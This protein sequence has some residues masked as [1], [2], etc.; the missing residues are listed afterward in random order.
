MKHHEFTFRSIG[1]LEK[2]EN[3]AQAL[4]DIDNVSKLCPQANQEIEKIE[5]IPKNSI[6]IQTNKTHLANGIAIIRT[7]E[8]DF[9]EGLPKKFII[10]NALM[11]ESFRSGNTRQVGISFETERNIS[12]TYY[13]SEELPENMRYAKTESVASQ[14]STSFTSKAKRLRVKTSDTVQEVSVPIQ[15]QEKK[16]GHVIETLGDLNSTLDG[17]HRSLNAATKHLKSSKH[18]SFGTQTTLGNI[19]YMDVSDEEEDED[20]DNT[21]NVYDNNQHFNEIL[22]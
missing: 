14:T 8:A 18:D 6:E 10:S 19:E 5:E 11:I 13:E 7:Q 12:E 22:A 2:T 16:K 20:I 3:D 9:V 21:S 4:D 17:L 15:K 1:I